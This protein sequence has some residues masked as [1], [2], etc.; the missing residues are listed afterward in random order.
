VDWLVPIKL[1]LSSAKPTEKAARARWNRTREI[2][3]SPSFLVVV[4]LLH[5][6]HSL[7]SLHSLTKRRELEMGSSVEKILENH[8]KVVD[9]GFVRKGGF[10]YKTYAVSTLRGGV[11]KSTL[12]FNLAYE[13]TA[14]RSLLVADICPQC[15]LT[16]ALMRDTVPEVTILKALQPVLLGPAFGDIPDDILY[17]V[18]KYCDSFKMR[19]PA[20]F[21]PGDSEMFAFPSTMYQQFQIASAQSNPKAVKSLLESLKNIL[22]KEAM[23]KKVDGI[24]LD[25]S[26]FYSGGTHL[27][28]CVSDAIIIPVRVDKHS[29]ESLDL[30]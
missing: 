1:T 10:R 26:P 16:E 18:S 11:G 29:I 28:W 6:L 7:H 19:K 23:D 4:F 15:N 20:Y 22:N 12:S 25:T 30:T 27:G 9:E 5:H 17:Q 3:R 2:S 21:I 24:L 13:L 8:Q 14:D